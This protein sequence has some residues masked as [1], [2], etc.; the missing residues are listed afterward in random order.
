MADTQTADVSNVEVVCECC[1]EDMST[2]IEL[3]KE[4]YCINCG[5]V[6]C[7]GCWQ[8]FGTIDEDDQYVC[9]F[10]CKDE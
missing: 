7:M 6:V 1:H 3:E 9:V 10:C 4:C 8:L 5:R 2:D